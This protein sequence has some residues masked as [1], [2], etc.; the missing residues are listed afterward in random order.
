MLWTPS[1]FFVEGL[2]GVE[3]CL[4]LSWC[5]RSSLRYF[6]N[7]SWHLNQSHCPKGTRPWEH[8]RAK[9]PNEVEYLPPNLLGRYRTFH[10]PRGELLDLRILSLQLRWME[11]DKLCLT[12]CRGSSCRYL[13]LACI[14]FDLQYL[15]LRRQQPPLYM[16]NS[17]SFGLSLNF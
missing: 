7:Y 1:C 11:S 3:G 10:Y 2:V 6:L 14:G 9:Q 17:L 5:R 8:Y 15:H 4:A 12:R 13:R 16:W